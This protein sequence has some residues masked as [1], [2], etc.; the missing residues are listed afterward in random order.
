M[1]G[2]RHRFRSAMVARRSEGSNAEVLCDDSSLSALRFKENSRDI[3]SCCRGPRRLSGGV[4]VRGN[5]RGVQRRNAGR[6]SFAE[7][8][9][10]VL[11]W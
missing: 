1:L 3:S 10:S 4:A 7:A 6:R 8:K 9:G 5:I 11:T 2:T